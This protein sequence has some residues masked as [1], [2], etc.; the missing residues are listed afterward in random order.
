MYQA[1]YCCNDCI[2]YLF[3][4]IANQGIPRH[5]NTRQYLDNRDHSGAIYSGILFS[6]LSRRTCTIGQVIQNNWRL[7]YMQYSDFDELKEIG[8]GGYGIVYT[9]SIK[10]IQP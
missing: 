1:D 4:Q 5:I 6:F 7:T 8:A 9:A 3:T 2:M 10:G